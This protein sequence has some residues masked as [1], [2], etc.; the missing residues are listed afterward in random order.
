MLTCRASP[1]GIIVS[2]QRDLSS[3]LCRKG[4]SHVWLIAISRDRSAFPSS[5]ARGARR[6]LGAGEKPTT[7]SWRACVTPA[8]RVRDSGG[9]PGERKSGAAPWRRRFA[10]NA[11]EVVARYGDQ[12]PAFE[13]LPGPNRPGPLGRPRLSEAA[14][15]R[16]LAEIYRSVKEEGQGRE[17]ELVAG[18]VARHIDGPAY[19]ARAIEAGRQSAS[20]KALGETARTGL[21]FDAV[22]IW[23]ELPEDPGPIPSSYLDSTD[24]RAERCARS[25]RSGRLD[26]GLR[27]RLEPADT[28]TG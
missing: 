27:V 6:A 22:A 20:W 21:P 8:C 25:V 14:F 10:A 2:Q 12:I 4:V 13:V 11:A 9:G 16:V 23:L 1:H 5:L 3:P 26:A 15:G 24:R 7:H 18:A 17:I 19:L 28:R